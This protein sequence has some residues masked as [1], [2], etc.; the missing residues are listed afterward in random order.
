MVQYPDHLVAVGPNGVL[1]AGL[2]I[3]ALLA[4]LHTAGQRDE[5]FVVDF[6]NTSPEVLIL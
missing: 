6:L 2:S 1:A 5:A 4:A 3:E